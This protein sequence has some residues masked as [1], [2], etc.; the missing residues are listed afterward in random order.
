MVYSIDLFVNDLVQLL[1]ELSLGTSSKPFHLYGQ[2]FGGIL[3]FEYLKRERPKHCLSVVLSSTPTNVQQVEDQANQLIQDIQRGAS[4]SDTNLAEA[5][6]IKHQ[7]QTKI[8]P[9]PLEEAY[10]AA[11][12]VFR[13]TTAIADYV[14]SLL[15]DDDSP[16]ETPALVLRGEHDF[17]TAPCIQGWKELFQS[18]TMLELEGCAHHGLLERPE[19]Y[20][21]T[22]E[23][24]WQWQEQSVLARAK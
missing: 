3:A 19:E 7:C 20:G 17:V 10:A 22:L 15:S 2:S 6:R 23:S 24:F 5:F 4:I 8:R 12:T 13:G 18:I 21:K 11:G 16:I 14:A 1:D 9:P